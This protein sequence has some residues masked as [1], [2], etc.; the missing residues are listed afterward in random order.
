MRDNKTGLIWIGLSQFALLASNFLLL[1][2]LT[3]QLSVYEFGE[4]SLCMSIVLF[5]RQ[6]LYDPISIAL[7][8]ECA[9]NASNLQR[10]SDGFRVVRY[11][12]DRIGWVFL[13]LG[14]FYF[15]YFKLA[16]HSYTSTL[17][18]AFCLVYV[19][20]N[21]A[22]GIYFNV[23]NSIRDRKPAALFSATDSVLKI[24]LVFL[25]F[26]F[27]N[28]SLE[29]SIAAISLGA[30]AV[31]GLLRYFVAN[32]F[33]Y[34]GSEKKDDYTLSKRILLVGMPFFLSTMLVAAKSV[35]DRW[36]LAGFLSVNDLAEY[37]VLLQLG[38]SPIILFLGMVQ[39]FVA[40]KIYCI[41]AL[42]D[43]DVANEL[44]KF[45]HKLLFIILIFTC[46]VSGGA[47]VL[48][49]WIFTLMVGKD[50]HGLAVF[51]PLFVISGA[52]SAAAG[53]FQIAVIGIFKSREAS[54]FVVISLII[55]LAITAILI[56]SSGFGG[57][58]AGLL[59]TSS[60]TLFI[61]WQALYCGVFRSCPRTQ[62][63]K[64]LSS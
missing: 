19:C 52:L 37:S 7:G 58:V 29:N 16:S 20:A 2:L 51:L 33:K 5:A 4:Y 48:A 32:R 44:K 10:V 61:Y 26:R 13:F 11:I 53:I 49:D 42:N 34:Y 35:G 21:G 63:A 56:R 39:T 15:L 8:K 25:F 3:S 62:N 50:Y 64:M 43:S 47:I 18:V 40:P 36:M 12:T 59:I 17:V 41:C 14:F 24:V 30:F 60:T 27:G 23:L 9:S 38:Y 57:A 6:V 55:S 28:N 54:K 22:Q 31:F 45:L 1:K 46:V